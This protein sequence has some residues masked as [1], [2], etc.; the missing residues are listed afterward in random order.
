MRISAFIFLIIFLGANISLFCK[1]HFVDQF[2]IENIMENEK[3]AEKKI[4]E[5]DTD[6]LKDKNFQQ[7]SIIVSAPTFQLKQ[8]IDLIFQYNPPFDHVYIIPP[9]AFM[10]S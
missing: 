2:S 5:D 8:Y 9:K 6:F 3:E 7:Y 1:A 10:L 4:S